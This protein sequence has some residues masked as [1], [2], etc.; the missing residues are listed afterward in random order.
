MIRVFRDTD[1]IYNTNGDV[2]IAPIKA[3]VHNSDNGD[4]YLELTCG[5]EYNDYI[6]ANNII[7]AP[8]PNGAQAFRIRE[9][10]KKAKRLE[11]KAWHVFYD[12]LNY[13]IADSYAFNMTAEQALNHFNDAT[14]T[15]SP[16][17]MQSDI[18]SVNN[19]RV[20][21]AS[22]G[23]AITQVIERWGGH[24]VRDNFNIS[25]KASIGQDNGII[26]QYR[27]NLQELIASY[28]WSSVVTKLLPV[29]KDGV[30][31]DELYIYS[32]TQYNI[33]F[34]KS[35]TFEQDIEAEDYPDEE[36]YIAALKED[37]RAQAENYI[38]IY[39]LP[40][41]NY[42]LKGN[43]EKVADIG[44]VIEVKDERIGVNVFT[45]VIAYEFDAVSEKYINLEFGNFTPSLSSLMGDIRQETA[46]QVSQATANLNIEVNTIVDALNL[47]SNAI[48]VL[49]KNKQNK[50]TEGAYIDITSDVI[51]CTLGAGDGIEIND[52]NIELAPIGIY[53]HVDN[54]IV[55]ID[56]NIATLFVTLPRPID[57]VYIENFILD[58]YTTAGSNNTVEVT[59][60]TTG[61]TYNVV[62]INDYCISIEITDAGSTLTGLA[63][64]YNA[65]FSLDISPV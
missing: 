48:T 10:E 25:V 22:L 34:T 20:V 31:L 6:E 58:I 15:E 35:I 7:V 64:A 51:K 28:D 40:V 39:S 61:I 12:S 1:K 43:P 44:D 14:D 27:K 16:F 41:I 3:R 57:D 63:G 29:G 38:A 59:S 17:T 42:T 36:S 62:V 53:S 5:A 65:Y 24:L 21:R 13:L 45:E 19:L 50:L 30:L 37:L 26:I 47:L 54:Q 4:Y 33:P 46:I 49:N 23:E 2:V 18:T 9:V 52:D 32:D 60:S 11:C 8:T 56:N 55:T